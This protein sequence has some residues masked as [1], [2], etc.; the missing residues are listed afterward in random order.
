MASTQSIY[1]FFVAPAEMAGADPLRVG[2]VISLSAAAGRATSPVSAVVL[3]SASL[4][5]AEPLAM[6]RRT[7]PALLAGLAATLIAAMLMG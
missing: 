1:G 4:A 5:G 7:G 3:L 6:L 2:A